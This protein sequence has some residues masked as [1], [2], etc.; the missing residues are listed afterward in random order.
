MCL[1]QGPQR[2]AFGSREEDKGLTIY[3]LGGH[4][5]HVTIIICYKFTPLDLMSRHIK[6]KF[7][8]SSG[9]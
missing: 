2:G 6:F 1:A 8:W 3:G 9:F 5:G 7:N 4:L